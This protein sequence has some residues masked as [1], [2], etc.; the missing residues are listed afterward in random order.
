MVSAVIGTVFVQASADECPPPAQVPDGLVG[1]LTGSLANDTPQP[2]QARV[3]RP[4]AVPRHGLRHRRDRN[5]TGPQFQWSQCLQL[6]RQTRMHRRNKLRAD[7]QGSDR[8]EAIAGSRDAA[9]YASRLTNQS[10]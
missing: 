3:L 10:S 4:V 7:Q 2:Q 9:L 5:R 6:R 8:G 1:I